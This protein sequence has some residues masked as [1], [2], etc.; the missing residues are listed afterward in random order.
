MPPSRVAFL[1]FLW[2]PSRLIVIASTASGTGDPPGFPS[3]PR[4]RAGDRPFRNPPP[5][6]LV[7]IVRT[8]LRGVHVSTS[9]HKAGPPKPTE[10]A[11][12]LTRTDTVA[13]ITASWL[14]QFEAARRTGSPRDAVPCCSHWRD[15]QAL[16]WHIKTVNG[17]R[18]GCYFARTSS[19]GRPRPSD[20]FQ[21]L[22]PRC[23][24]PSKGGL[25]RRR[26]GGGL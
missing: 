5:S 2:S 13:T 25:Q 6:L 10:G 11:S 14:V 9:G 22:N 12:M 3:G 18:F 23:P 8:I 1:I 19:A 26:G 17:E 15:V 24:E 4:A 20:W 7:R 21:V 16:T